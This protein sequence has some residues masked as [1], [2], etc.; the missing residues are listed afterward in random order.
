MPLGKGQKEYV[1]PATN[2]RVFTLT[3]TNR[4]VEKALVVIN[5]LAEGF[6]GYSGDDWYE[7]VATDYFK[8]DVKQ[9][10][11]MYKL[12]LNSQ[13]LDYGL[14]ISTFEKAYYEVVRNSIYQKTKTPA[15]AVDAIKNNYK[16]D[17]DSV[18]N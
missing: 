13:T 4:D 17:L 1:S 16:N 9:N 6:G 11:K 14:C 8:N 18:F 7:D 2:A 5:A 3:T 10:L 12:I 15:A